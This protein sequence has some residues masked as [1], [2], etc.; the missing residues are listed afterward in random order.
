[1]QRVKV[2]LKERSYEI[3]IGTEC[4][5]GVSSYVKELSPSGTVTIVTNTT[6]FGLYGEKLQDALRAQDLKVHTV[7]IPDGEQYK[8]YFW[9]YHI[10]TEMLQAGLDRGSSLVAL[11]GGV[12]GDIGAFCASLYMRGI[13]LVQVPTTLLSQVDSSVGGKTGVNHPLGKNMIG[14][15]YQPK[16]VWIDVS[17]LKTLPRRE[18]LAGVAEVLKY[19]VILDREF[20]EFLEGSRKD[21]LNLEPE[22]LQKVVKRCCE[23]KAEVVSRDET[24]TGLRAILNYGHTIGHAI[25]TLTN[26]RLYLHGEAVAIGMVAEAMI[27]ES[28][29]FLSSTERE[30]IAKTTRDYGLPVSVKENLEVS[31]MVQAMARDKKARKG[32][33]TFVLPEEIGRVRIERDVPEEAVI[34]AIGKVKEGGD[35][36]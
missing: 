4:I 20:F 26:Y 10:L 36:K 28:L 25:E 6:V 23:L 30:R 15:F 7:V 17:T 5:E 21:I 11:G 31:A 34:K 35:E 14:T 8:D 13:A 32:S 33:L 19:G 12:V 27:S 16:L 9:A 2:S 18:F 1:M 29:G 3:F 22:V 24:E